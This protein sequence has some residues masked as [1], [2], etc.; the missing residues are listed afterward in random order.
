MVNKIN[1]IKQRVVHYHTVGK[2]LPKCP[3]HNDVNAGSGWC[4]SECTFSS[5]FKYL[6]DPYT[7]DEIYKFDC[8]YNKTLTKK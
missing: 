5:N 1:I 8:S 2:Y 6:I 3:H 7:L 4:K